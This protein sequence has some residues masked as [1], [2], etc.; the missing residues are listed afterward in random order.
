MARTALRRIRLALTAFALLPGCAAAPD[1]SL[2]RTLALRL[3]EPS[4]QEARGRMVLKRLLGRDAGTIGELMAR[5]AQEEFEADGFAVE[6]AAGASE[7]TREE[8][9]E[10]L[11]ASGGAEG[12]LVVRVGE[13]D[14]GVVETAGKA[15]IEYE[16][17]ILAAADGRASWTEK[18]SRRTVTL[19]TGEQRDIEAF[20]R[21]LVVEALRSL[22]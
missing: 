13:W 11:R 20:V 7:G 12:L 8:A 18:V 14:L 17:E 6:E 22:P 16:L 2:P 5:A 15:T 21:R 4:A 3:E 10:R 19:R 9:L 1:A